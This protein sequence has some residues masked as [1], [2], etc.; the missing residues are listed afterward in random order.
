MTPDFSNKIIWDEY[1]TDHLRSIHMTR[2]AVGGTGWVWLRTQQLCRTKISVSSIVHLVLQSHTGTTWS[3]ETK[4]SKDKK[5]NRPWCHRLNRY[6]SEGHLVPKHLLFMSDKAKKT[7][8]KACQTFANSLS[9][10]DIQMFTPRLKILSELKRW[11]C[12]WN[13]VWLKK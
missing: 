1:S 11:P 5:D 8:R 3:R 2:Q 13:K 12:W 10:Q 6:N 4:Y 7:T 9:Y